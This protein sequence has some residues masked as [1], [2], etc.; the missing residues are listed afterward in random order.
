MNNYMFII[1]F[2]NLEEIDNFLETIQP[3][4]TESRINNLSQL[5]TR[6]ETES[7]I[8]KTNK[9]LPTKSPG[10]GGIKGRLYQT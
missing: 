10:P 6:S 9:N 7:V 8:K 1:W 5:I 2:D 4:K 3:T